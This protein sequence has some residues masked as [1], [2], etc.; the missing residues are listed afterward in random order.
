MTSQIIVLL[1]GIALLII[2][3]VGGNRIT[4]LKA[5]I[6]IPGWGRLPLAFLGLGS[7]ALSLVFPSI[8]P[9]GDVASSSTHACRR[10]KD[11][12]A[13]TEGNRSE[14]EVRDFLTSE[15]FFNVVTEPAFAP[16]AAPD[17][18][19]GQAPPPGTILCPR[20]LVTIKVTR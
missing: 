10:P 8:I 2:A 12:P 20:D 14:T 17:V 4:I 18:V 9:G 5:D 19:V 16:G 11:L 13:V 1:T 15:G 7:I 6:L 3:I